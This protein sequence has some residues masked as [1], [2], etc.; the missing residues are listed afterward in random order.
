MHTCVHEEAGNLGFERSR[1]ERAGLWCR[2]T[3]GAEMHQHVSDEAGV[4][5]VRVEASLRLQA[6]ILELKPC[7]K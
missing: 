2:G 3:C 4:L 6:A 1:T 5:I 7:R